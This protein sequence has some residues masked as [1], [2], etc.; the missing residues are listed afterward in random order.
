[1]IIR[2]AQFRMSQRTLTSASVIYLGLLV[3]LFALEFP[4]EAQQEATL[5]RVGILMSSPGVEKYVDSFRRGLKRLGHIEGKTVIIDY[6]IAQGPLDHYGEL[7]AEL[8]GLKVDVIVTGSTPAALAV[9]SATRTIPI[10]MAAV[11]DPVGVGLVESLSKP[12]GNVTGLSMR[13]TE[14]SS[15]RLQLIKEVIPNIR[16]I[17]I[18]WNP[19]SDADR[20][21][22][23]ESH[24]VAQRM[25]LE[26]Q[27]IE[28]H[29]PSDFV[30]DLEA[31]TT[32]RLDAVIVLRSA[33]FNQY[34]DK[35]VEIFAL[36]RLPA[37]Y[38]NE[39][40]VEAGGLMFYGA[41]LF[42]LYS[43]AA[44]FVDK[45]LKGAKPAELPV[46][47]AL[48]VDFV[49]NLNAAKQIGLSI[50]PEVLQRA[51]KVIR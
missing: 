25:D 45:I 4:A 1:M 48:K 31:L 5:P 24:Y 38:Q 43:R 33:Y 21:A 44:T 17:G 20:N 42:D 6:Q 36:N 34:I 47:Q 46:E 9:K 22:L 3:M 28:L 14:L 39:R 13:A 8:V 15:K 2:A 19:K 10:V 51:D 26:V 35:I 32:K 12:G 7:A 30:R 50:P 37:M 49:I 16:R 29:H 41:N 11:A 40:F 23:R 18:L 27:S